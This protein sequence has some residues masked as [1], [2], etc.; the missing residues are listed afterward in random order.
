MPKGFK[1]TPFLQGRPAKNLPVPGETEI[2][3]D[4]TGVGTK[5]VKKE[6][7]LMRQAKAVYIRMGSKR[8]YKAI[9]KIYHWTEEWTSMIDR[10]F[11]WPEEAAPAGKLG[12]L[13]VFIHAN[14]P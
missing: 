6:T 8:S 12:H 2:D 13:L 5:L 9:A 11:G 3:I 1:E 10:S 4:D 14:P 7:E